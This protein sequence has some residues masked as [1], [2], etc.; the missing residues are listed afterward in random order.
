MFLQFPDTFA[1][2]ESQLGV[3]WDCM[4]STVKPLSI[5]SEGTMKINNKYKKIIVAEVIYMADVQGPEKVN[6]VQICLL[7]CTAA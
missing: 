1:M 4:A 3:K 7:G 5:V 2:T 6:D